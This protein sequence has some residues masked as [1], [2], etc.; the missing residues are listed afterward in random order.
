MILENKITLVTGASR[1]IGQAIAVKLGQHGAVVIGTAT[2]QSGADSISQ[3]LEKA[4]T[5]RHGLC[6]KLQKLV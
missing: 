4:R 2:T 1:G 3:Y 5:Q 6:R